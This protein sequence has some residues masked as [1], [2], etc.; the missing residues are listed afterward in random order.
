MSV[1]RKDP[2][3]HGW[4]IFAEERYRPPAPNCF[5]STEVHSDRC[6][7]CPGNE[8]MTPAEIRAIRP[9]SSRA[10]TPGWSV[11]TIPNQFAVLRIEGKFDRR[12]E[13]LYD[14][15][16][17]IGAHEV[18]IETPEHNALLSGYSVE[19]LQ[20]ILW[21]LRERVQDLLKDTR[22]RYIQVF[23]NYGN[24]SGATVSHPH[25]QI[26]A[27]PILPRSIGEEIDHAH[28]YWRLKER[29]IFCDIIN[30][31]SDSRR[32][33]YE[34]DGFVVLEPFASKFPFETWVYPK[35][36]LWAFHL[37]PDSY[38]PLL[39]DAL[40]VTMGAIARA[41]GDPAYNL[42]F[43]SAPLQLEKKYHNLRAQ[44]QDYYHW[45]IEIIPRAT[46]V[47]GFE[48]GT[49]FYINSVLPEDAAEYLRSVIAEMQG[50]E[51]EP[52]L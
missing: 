43:H 51:A 16:N 12:G 10:N 11:R 6:P 40:K 4:V 18:V 38:L 39:A 26:V 50:I 14:M 15:M 19:K 21:M 3:S 8:R 22:F 17:G 44:V 42:I 34:N 1:L 29:C 41:L 24:V 48:Y 25:S 2:L 47:A 23:R 5:I 33:V 36:H 31:D 20:E 9:P 45:H 35:E 27:L 30:Q 7:F 52:E 13:G 28:E 37:L 32:L 49:G 46:G